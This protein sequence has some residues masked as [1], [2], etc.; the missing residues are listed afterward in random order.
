MFKNFDTALH[1][2]EQLLPWLLTSGI[3][4]FAILVAGFII[5]SIL[6]FAIERTVRKAVVSSEFQSRAAE[7]KREDTI[8]QVLFGTSH[9]ILWIVVSV[10]VL[11]ELGVNVAP[12]L[13][14][15]GIVGVAVG[16]GGQYLIR[17]IITGVFL[18]WENQFR[19][20]DVITIG[21]TTGTVESITLRI[22]ILRD[23][24]GTVHTIPNGEIKQTAN[25]TKD[26]SRI[27]MNIGVG[28]GDDLEKVTDVVN[29]VG[30]A[31]SEDSEWKDKI[32]SAPK[33]VRVNSLGDSSV[34]IRITGE[35]TAGDQW[36]V[37]G[38]LRKRLK[39][40]FDKEGI[41]IPFPQRVI[42]KGK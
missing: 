14:G 1:I 3:R 25:R 21:N 20:G 19:V 42:H 2:Q 30:I 15:A 16:F 41:E 33:F 37:A 35:T 26:F 29:R 5:D 34:E 36:G 18:I 22:T 4:L 28:Y 8:I 6:H 17:D 32:R 39:Y 7:K 11:S 13:A 24:D 27:N 12:I 23:M 10:M 31:L 40:A 9:I 38:E